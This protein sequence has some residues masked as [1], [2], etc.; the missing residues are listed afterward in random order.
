MQ[1]YNFIYVD[2]L[3]LLQRLTKHIEEAEYTI[4]Y[5]QKIH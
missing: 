5:K 2:E 1:T 3:D 4:Y